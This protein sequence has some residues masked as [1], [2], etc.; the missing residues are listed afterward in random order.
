VFLHFKH[1]QPSLKGDA[2]YEQVASYLNRLGVRARGGKAINVENVKA[3]IED[4]KRLGVFQAIEACY[5]DT[6]G[7]LLDFDKAREYAAAIEED[8]DGH[9]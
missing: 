3:A 4:K 1:T 2:R 7:D 9:S 5:E 8:P 6:P